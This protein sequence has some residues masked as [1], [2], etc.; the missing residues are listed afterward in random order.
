MKIK[1][2]LIPS[3]VYKDI[4]CNVPIACVD[5]VVISH[6]SK[7]LLVRRTQKPKQG[8]FWFPGGR[9]FHGE[10]LEQ[11]ALRKV[12]EETGLEVSLWNCLG[13][14]ET[15]FEDSEFDC[16]SHTIN[17][18]FIAVYTGSKRIVKISLNQ[19]SSEYGWFVGNEPILDEYIK[20]ICKKI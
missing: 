18:T 6:D 16:P 12:K 9:L 19:T 15:F 3:S 1:K 11:C 14:F 5:V 13:T 4:V 20:N 7:I 2:E 17:T 10:T 8:F